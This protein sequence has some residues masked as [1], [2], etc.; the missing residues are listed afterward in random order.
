M[1]SSEEAAHDEPQI[2]WSY[3]P[4]GVLAVLAIGST[5]FVGE[6]DGDQ[7]LKYPLVASER[8]DIEH[9]ARIYDILGDHPRI[10]RCYGLHGVG[11][12]LERAANGT[13]RDVLKTGGSSFRDQL[14]W[15]RQL[16]EAVVYIHSKQVFHCDISPRNCFITDE[17][18][19]KLGDFQGMYVAPDG[20]VYEGYSREGSK[21]SLPRKPAK[22]DQYSDLFAVGSTLYEIM[23]GQEPYEDLDSIDDM[24]EIESLFSKGTFP[25][26]DFL[27]AHKAIERCW[28]QKYDCAQQC[29]DDLVA[30]E[31]EMSSAVA[32]G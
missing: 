18:D 9:E 15:A 22:V 27:P 8:E 17:Y 21:A 10:L 6:L 28:R 31:A 25:N 1:S 32:Y 3:Q 30:I 24:E 19:L 12:R 4:P 7:V 26:T 14:K 29:L 5:S 2:I 11:L 20:T 23:A 16:L 13:L